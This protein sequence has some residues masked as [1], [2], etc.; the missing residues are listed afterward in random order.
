MTSQTLVKIASTPEYYKKYGIQP[1][2]VALKEDGMQTD[3]KPGNYE[4]WYADIN[5][6]DG[7]NLVITFHTKPFTSPQLPLSPMVTIDFNGANGQNISKHFNGHAE[8][9]SAS[10]EQCDVKIGK[11]EFKGNLKNYTIHVEIDDLVADVAMTRMIPSWRPST[12]H[13]LYGSEGQYEYG[14]VVA[15]PKGRVTATINYA[16]QENSYQGFGYH[17]HNWGNKNLF[18]LKHHGFWGR[19]ELDGYTF[20][21]AI[22]YAPE[23]FGKQ[24]F[25]MFMLA[26]G[27]QVIAD[28]ESKVTF[29][30]SNEFIDKV[31]KKPIAK[32]ISYLYENGRKKYKISYEIKDV[33]LQMKMIDVLPPEQKAAAKAKNFDPAYLRFTGT[34]TLEVFDNDELKEKH[35]GNAIWESMYFGNPED[36]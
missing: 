1:E 28:D 26:K 8:D 13:V 29:S 34:A 11:S 23:K 24:N 18:E 33:I 36:F 30:S 14:W 32:N 20:I 2:H 6:D 25:T 7:S 10:K 17:D 22:N 21:N 5:F 4:W 12:G 3:G 15:I 16:G 27:D 9:F 31:T 19:A 35:D